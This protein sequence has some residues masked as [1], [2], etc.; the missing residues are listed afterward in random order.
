MSRL[1]IEVNAATVDRYGP[2]HDRQ[3]EARSA[4][5]TCTCF[6][7]PAKPLKHFVSVLNGD[8]GPAILTGD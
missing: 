1:R 8:T 7:N 3:A 4:F 2:L 6:V 5:R